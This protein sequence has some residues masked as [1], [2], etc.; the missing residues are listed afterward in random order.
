VSITKRY[1]EAV[2][3]HDWAVAAECVAVGVRRVGPFGDVY[4]GR[5]TY[6]AFLRDLMPT[7]AGYSMTIHRVLECEGSAVMVEL[8]EKVEMDGQTIDTPECLV[9]DIDDHGLIAGINIYIQRL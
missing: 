9:F 8:N 5:E 1:L 2:A 7:L 3:A 6:I 4:E